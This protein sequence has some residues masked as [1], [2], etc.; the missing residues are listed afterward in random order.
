MND[1]RKSGIALIVG[2]MAGVMTMAF[3]PTGAA[4]VSPD[5][6]EHLVRM[7][8]GAHALALVSALMLFLG[9]CGQGWE[10][11]ANSLSKLTRVHARHDVIKEH[12]INVRI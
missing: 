11:L 1:N 10:L 12:K 8:G 3:H 9:T 6:M 4:T 5:Q 7:S 2:S